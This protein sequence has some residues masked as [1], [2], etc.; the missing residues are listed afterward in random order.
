MRHLQGLQ[1][2]RKDF[3][4]HDSDVCPAVPDESAMV[5]ADDHPAGVESCR[6]GQSEGV[7]ATRF[8]CSFTAK[9]MVIADKMERQV[10]DG[11]W[12]Q[13]GG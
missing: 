10:H 6:S 4:S 9:G 2:H 8:T 12:K 11:K 3:P 5:Q 7:E 1:L 13:N